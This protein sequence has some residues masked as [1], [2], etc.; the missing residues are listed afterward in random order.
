MN[1]KYRLVLVS[2]MF[3]VAN[4]SLVS[5]ASCVDKTCVDV[6]TEDNQLVITAHRAGG[7]TSSKST[8]K[9]APKVAPKAAPKAVT[10]KPVASPPKLL[11]LPKKTATASQVKKPVSKP[12]KKTVKKVVA[13]KSTTTASLSDRL[14]KLLPV[15]DINYQPD[16]DPIVNVPIYFW[17]NTPSRFTAVVPILN[18]LVYVDL[19]PTFTWRFGDGGFEI[20]KL[21]GAAYPIGGISHSYKAAGD[22]GVN[23]TISWSGTWSV[24]GVIT[25][26]YGNSLTQSISTTLNVVSAPTKFIK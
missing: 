17:S 25:P 24:N 1:H 11:A 9:V 23:L 12:V 18:L 4:T 13:S 10:T 20:S 6:L 19:T 14:T 15:G 16:I 26:I 21:P 2:L 3:L 5:A 8:P 22:Y 7:V